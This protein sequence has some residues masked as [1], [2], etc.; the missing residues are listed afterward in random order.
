MIA[1]RIIATS[2]LA[3]SGLVASSLAAVMPAT[4]GEPAAALA[5]RTELHAISTLTLSDAQ[6]LADLQN[7]LC[8]CAWCCHDS[9]SPEQF[10]FSFGPF[11]NNFQSLMHHP[12]EKAQTLSGHLR[13]RS[14][15]TWFLPVL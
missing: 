1:S 9:S 8:A 3:A 7:D 5:A 15:R 11:L 2:I 4:A 13:F 12:A 6:F 14:D 10:L